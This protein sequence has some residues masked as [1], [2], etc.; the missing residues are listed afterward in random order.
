L[1]TK[2]SYGKLAYMMDFMGDDMTQ[3]L[4]FGEMPVT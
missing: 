1:Q 4:A 2:L 3:N